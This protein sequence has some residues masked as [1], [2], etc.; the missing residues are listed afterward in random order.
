MS[1]G[2]THTLVVPPLERVKNFDP[3]VS[4]LND[5]TALYESTRCFMC[6]DAPCIS[7][8]P[9]RINIPE[10]ISRI[11]SGNYM[12]A[13]KVIRES[14]IF[15]G[16]CGYV[17][18]V[19][20]LCEVRCIRNNLNDEPVAIGMLQRFAFEKERTRGLIKFDQAKTNGKKVAVIGSGPAGLSLAYEMARRGYKVVVFDSNPVAGGLLTNGI[21][22][23]KAAWTVAEAEIGNIKSYG[24]EVVKKAVKEVRPLLKQYDAVFIGTGAASC[25]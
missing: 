2:R 22:P 4:N 23:W 18:P 10:F 5:R 9:T 13:A 17:C 12:G 7:G 24:I 19:E 11:K 21:L 16:E 6:V 15:G 8:C 14:N 1:A 3:Y 25:M 20:R